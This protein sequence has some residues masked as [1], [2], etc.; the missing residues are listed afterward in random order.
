MLTNDI[1]T[2]TKQVIWGGGKGRYEGGVQGQS[3]YRNYHMN[4]IKEPALI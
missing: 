1:F 3:F 2:Y 4:G